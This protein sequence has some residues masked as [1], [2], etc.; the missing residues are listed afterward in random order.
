MLNSNFKQIPNCFFV[1]IL[2]EIEKLGI[3]KSKVYYISF[4]R[5]CTV[6]MKIVK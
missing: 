2:K 3:H 1:S 6:F 4:F 5:A